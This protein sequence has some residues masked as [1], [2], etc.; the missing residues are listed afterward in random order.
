MFS[1]F[2]C[3]AEA[4]NG[5]LLG[6]NTNDAVSII[7]AAGIM[8]GFKLSLIGFIALS[9]FISHLGSFD[10]HRRNAAV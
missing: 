5:A 7:S 3:D 6:A 8:D 1:L 10:D 9:P 4:M 2:L